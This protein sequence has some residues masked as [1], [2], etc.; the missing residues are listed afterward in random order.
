MTDRTDYETYGAEEEKGLKESFQH[1]KFLEEKE[2]R[3]EKIENLKYKLHCACKRFLNGF[4]TRK[5]EKEQAKKHKIA[6]K[7]YEEQKKLREFELERERKEDEEQQ[8]VK[9][10]F[11]SIQFVVSV[12]KELEEDNADEFYK[13]MQNLDENK[14]V[15]AGDRKFA[16][17]KTSFDKNVEKYE[18]YFTLSENENSNFYYI[19]FIHWFIEQKEN[20]KGE[21]I[22]SSKNAFLGYYLEDHK[23]V[24][25]IN[26]DAWEVK[27]DKVKG[28]YSFAECLLQEAKKQH[29]LAGQNQDGISEDYLEQGE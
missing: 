22:A 16:I 6:E 9:A 7:E 27:L 4:E 19:N 10:K 18:G 13:V 14:V 3:S 29:E 2:K 15:F 5:Q 25:K 12:S 8:L 17:K 24:E 23:K 28:L 1:E 21:V 20:E 11:D 26:Q